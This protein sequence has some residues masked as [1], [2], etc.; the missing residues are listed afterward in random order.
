MLVRSLLVLLAAGASAVELPHD[1]DLV[2]EARIS[3][4]RY[5]RHASS[6][7]AQLESSDH[8]QRL[9]AFRIIGNS[10]DYSLPPHLVRYLDPDLNDADIVRAALRAL[11]GLGAI[12]QEPAI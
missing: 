7:V 9:T 6:L 8:D 1:L 2:A 11:V 4:D 5:Q 3:N 10:H 12:D